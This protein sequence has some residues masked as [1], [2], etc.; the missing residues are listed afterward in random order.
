[1]GIG[2]LAAAGG[3]GV[4]GAGVMAVGVVYLVIGI[5]LLLFAIAFLSLKRWAWWGMLIM[6]VVSVIFGIVGMAA[7][8]FTTAG[9]IGIIV[10]L[11]IIAYLYSRRVKEAFFGARA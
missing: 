7:S 8:G 1:M 4:V 6:L 11:L 10:D 5:L 9:L 3:V 2:G